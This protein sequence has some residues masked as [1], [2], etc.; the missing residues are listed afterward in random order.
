[1]VKF[2][3]VLKFVA[4]TA[5]D[6]WEGYNE[7]S[8]RFVERT[9]YNERLMRLMLLAA[10]STPADEAAIHEMVEASNAM[11]RAMLE[12]MNFAVRQIIEGDLSPEEALRQ[13]RDAIEALAVENVVH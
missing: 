1:M 10:D 7:G 2:K 12:N 8:M 5:A 3:K 9:G 4:H 6:V 11:T 13:T